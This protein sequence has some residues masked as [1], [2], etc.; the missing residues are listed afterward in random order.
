MR[1]QCA[2]I[3]SKKYSHLRCPNQVKEGG[4][5]AAAGAVQNFCAKHCKTKILWVN[6]AQQ[7]PRPPLT[8]KQKVAVDKIHRFWI[9][10]GRAAARRTHGPALYDA[11]ISNNSTDIYTLD[12]I[13]SIPFTY[14]YSYLD[15]HSRVWTFDLRFLMHLLQYGNLKNPYTQDPIPEKVLQRL[16][17]RSEQLRAQKVPIV[18]M[19]DT[20]LTPDQIWNQKVMDVFLKLTS[21][22]YG[23]NMIWYESM[24]LAHHVAFYRKL[25][26]LWNFDLR[27]SKAQKDT[28]VP[29]HMAGRTILFKWSPQQTVEDAH[30]IRWWRKHNLALMNSFFV[31]GQDRATQGCGALYILTGLANVHPRVAEA[32]PWL[33]Q[34]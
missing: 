24:G 13:Q 34:E 16:Q 30:D 3:K 22:G 12:K 8:R 20:T 5:A 32:F 28:I 14:H 2:S 1:L 33:V 19:D 7:P 31:R 11:N 27:L 18:Y 4:S 23:V 26:N 6:T 17:R 15:E 9:L 29:G 10:K 25:Y 21:L